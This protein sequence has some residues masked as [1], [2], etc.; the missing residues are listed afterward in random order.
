[1]ECVPAVSAGSEQMASPAADGCIAPQAEIAALLSVNATVPVR[2]A[3]PCGAVTVAVNDTATGCWLT[4]EGFN[5]ET[6]LRLVAAVP[7]F[8]VRVLLLELK[9]GSL[10]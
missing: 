10:A 2:A 3:P 4:V 1:M 9:F 8:W 7:T 5:D 6:R